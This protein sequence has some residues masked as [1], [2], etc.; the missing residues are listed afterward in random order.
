MADG[1]TGEDS[2]VMLLEMLGTAS[3]TPSRQ[4][5]RTEASEIVEKT[6]AQL[7]ADYRDAVRM[8]DLENRSAAD[9]AAA[10][11]RS[12]GAFHMLRSRAHVRLKSLL[13]SAS[14]FFTD[15]G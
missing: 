10:M 3:V 12:V 4:A 6:L 8:Y 2:C 1:S 7:P 5:A 14:Q 13:G 15:P 9:T 11:H